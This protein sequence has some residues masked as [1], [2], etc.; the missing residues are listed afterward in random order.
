MVVT[1]YK[2]NLEVGLIKYNVM[3]ANKQFKIVIIPL[4]MLEV[5]INAYDLFVILIFKKI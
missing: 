5:Q 1:V 3:E 2:K 4:D